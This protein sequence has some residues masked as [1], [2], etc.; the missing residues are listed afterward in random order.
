[1]ESKTQLCGI[2]SFPLPLL[3]F[4][5]SNAEH[6]ACMA[7]TS[8]PWANSPAQLLY[9]HIKNPIAQE[10]TSFSKLS[11]SPEHLGLHLVTLR[12]KLSPSHHLQDN[13]KW[14]ARIS[15]PTPTLPGT[16]TETPLKCFCS[17]SSDGF[18]HVNY[19][20]LIL[21]APK[22]PYSFSLSN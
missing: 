10:K 6:Q 13:G 12:C 3:G 14:A 8:T 2:I 22:S 16:H 11:Q 17:F 1:M 19:S 21:L 7:S 4:Q 15:P 5:Q 9:Y 18:D 20:A